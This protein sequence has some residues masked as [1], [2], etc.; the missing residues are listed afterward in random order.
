M[1]RI[2][3]NTQKKSPSCPLQ[4]KRTISFSRNVPKDIKAEDALE[5]VVAKRNGDRD[6]QQDERQHVFFVCE[7]VVESSR[8]RVDDSSYAWP[9]RA[10]GWFWLLFLHI[11]SANAHWARLVEKSLRRTRTEDA[12]F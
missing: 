8:R 10:R 4:E 1:V 6:Q 11:Y 7:G 2:R 12:I 3:L 9:P 5:A